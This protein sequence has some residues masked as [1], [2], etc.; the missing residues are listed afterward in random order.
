MLNGVVDNPA[1]RL[2]ELPLGDNVASA[3]YRLDGDTVIL[4]HTEVPHELTGQG[5]GSRL[6]EA[7]FEEI[8]RTGRKAV[9]KCPFMSRF[10][11][12]RP[13]LGSLIAG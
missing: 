3:Y 6:A 8:R 13:E 10:A 12:A 9:V 1:A 7:V 11:T 2:F 5:I 4:L